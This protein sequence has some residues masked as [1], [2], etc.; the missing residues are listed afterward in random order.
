MNPPSNN[1][2]PSI[3][4]STTPMETKFDK[5]EGLQ[6]NLEMF[7]DENVVSRLSI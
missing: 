6:G 7:Q 1:A 5:D 2:F 4:P 3:N